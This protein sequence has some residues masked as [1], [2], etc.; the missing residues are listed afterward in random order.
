M[1][2]W[3]EA[4]RSPRVG[5]VG[6]TA[7]P[8]ADTHARGRL[9][10]GQAGAQPAGVIGVGQVDWVAVDADPGDPPVYR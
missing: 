2:L 4:G 8:S 6:A 9:I 7:T 1:M 10:G 5:T 3:P